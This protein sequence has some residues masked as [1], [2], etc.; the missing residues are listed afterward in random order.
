MSAAGKPLG[1]VRLGPVTPAQR[2]NTTK[3]LPVSRTVVLPAATRLV[4]VTITATGG[5]YIDGYADNVS[6]LLK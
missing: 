2:A 6:L 1:S 3:L 4:R 5:G